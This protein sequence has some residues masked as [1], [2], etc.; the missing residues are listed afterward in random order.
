M[1][2]HVF[3]CFSLDIPSCF[4]CNYFSFQNIMLKILARMLPRHPGICLHCQ[5]SA[6]L[7][8]GDP[9]GVIPLPGGVYPGNVEGIS[10]EK[11]WKTWNSTKNH[12]Q[13]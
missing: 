8:I 2:F 6:G 9:W 13:N 4:V 11:Q 5:K 1:E 3:H 12:P 7:V 10:S